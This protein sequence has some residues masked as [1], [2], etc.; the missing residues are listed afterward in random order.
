MEKRD[1][2]IRLDHLWNRRAQLTESEWGE[3]YGLIGRILGGYNPSILRSLTDDKADYITEFFARKVFEAAHRATAQSIH[4]GA[5]RKFFD[6]FLHDCLDSQERNLLYRAESLNP[7]EE[8]DE[9]RHRIEPCGCADI[10]LDVLEEHGLSAGGVRESAARWLDAQEAWVLV[11]LG[12]HHCP[13]ADAS[14]S[15]V[16][17]AE[18]NAIASYHHKARKLGLTHRKEEQ[19]QAWFRGTLLGQWLEHDMRLAIEAGNGP[20]IG[21][22]LALLCEVALARVATV[23]KSTHDAR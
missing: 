18:R 5:I 10:S 14:L 17:L 6:N 9:P 22:A 20:A 16:R 15:L 3:L 12:L 2:D 21:A 11:Y 13:D 19:H 7:D 23:S 8:D 4:A 1:L